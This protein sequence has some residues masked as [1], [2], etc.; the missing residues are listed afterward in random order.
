MITTNTEWLQQILQANRD[1]CA[2]IDPDKITKQATACPYAIITC[3]DPRVNLESVG[4]APFSPD[5][6]ANSQ[7][8][9]IRTAG[10]GAEYRSLLMGI[11]L[12]GFKE[13]AVIL[14]TDCGISQAHQEIDTL[15]KNMRKKL[16]PASFQEFQ[17]SL[18]QPFR[19]NLLEWLGTFR[20]PRAAVRK[21]VRDIKDH[22]IAPA[23]LIV[24]GLLYEVSAGRVELIVTTN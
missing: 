10:A 7:V 23:D 22:P 6:Q 15:I 16:S 21:Q 24:H 3:I 1:F 5:G 9:V 17:D 2:R 11:H 18:G 19:E 13:I 20:D 4:I 8:K 14:H 12:A